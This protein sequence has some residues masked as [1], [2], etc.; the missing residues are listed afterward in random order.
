MTPAQHYDAAVIGSGQGGSP[1][2]SALASALA[3]PGRKTTLV[4][5]EHVGGA[6]TN[7]GCTPTKTRIANAKVAYLDRRSADYGV[8]V[9]AVAV[10]MSKVRQRKRDLLAAA[11]RTPN[12]DTLNVEAATS[13]ADKRGFVTID[14][15]L[16]TNVEGVWALGDVKGGPASP[17]FLTTISASSG[18]TS[19]RAATPPLPGALSPTRSSR[20]RSSG[21]LGSARQRPTSRA[22]KSSR[23]G[24]R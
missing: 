11:G 5:R 8:Q 16:E 6:C 10:A 24:C 3:G 9:G 17:T 23:R 13:E 7:E 15:Q 21:V 4:K 1:L 12:T 19:W 20:T 2:A 18:R 14:E 22:A